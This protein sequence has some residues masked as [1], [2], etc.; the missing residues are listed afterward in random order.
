MW[1]VS[2]WW[3]RL[4]NRVNAHCEDR[5]GISLLPKDTVLLFKKKHHKNSSISVHLKQ[6]GSQIQHHL[7]EQQVLAQP[8]SP[9][10]TVHSEDGSSKTFT[11]VHLWFTLPFLQNGNKPIKYP[12]PIHAFIT[13]RLWSSKWICKTAH[14]PQE[15][16]SHVSQSICR[17]EALVCYTLIKSKK[18][19][20][21]AHSMIQDAVLMKS[22]KVWR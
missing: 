4:Y 9:S 16:S 5:A 11:V 13:S 2:K 14:T 17:W 7:V 15:Q 22:K 12:T 18:S 6:K 8:R 19:N 1:L 20:L 21:M 10:A 3:K